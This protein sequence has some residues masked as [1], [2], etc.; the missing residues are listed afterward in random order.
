[1]IVYF[2]ATPLFRNRDGIAT[3]TIGILE[4]LL[5]RQDDN[6]YIGIAFASDKRVTGL[7]NEGDRLSFLFLPFSRR[8]YNILFKLFKLPVNV[9][10]RAKP[11]IVWYPNFVSFPYLTRVPKLVT[12]HDLTFRHNPEW[13]SKRNGRYLNRFV[14][15]SVE[16]AAA[17]ITISKSI[18]KEIQ[19]EYSP[20]KNIHVIPPSISTTGDPSG[21]EESLETF[22]L[23][24]KYLLYIGTIEPRK[25]IG[26][27]L[28]AYQLLPS[29]TK[30]AY[31]LVLVGKSGW[32]NDDLVKQIEDLK[33]QGVRWLGFTDDKD[34]L[35]ILHSAAVFILPSHYEGFGIPI[36]EAMS[37][38]VPVITSNK[39]A[40]SEIAEGYGMTIDISSPIRLANSIETLL[41]DSVLREKLVKSGRRRVNDYSWSK[42]A[43][44]LSNHFEQYGKK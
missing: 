12:V 28:D 18:R 30:A 32:K 7:L 29:K 21:F 31:D 1:M 44:M 23:N 11:D 39:G 16:K 10:L 3:Y 42:S 25:N 36:L 24:K 37:Q 27:L 33:H 4:E 2:D 5:A 8:I 38:G 15:W 14:P 13:V 9:F 17:I 43:E 35:N 41:N 40:T 26:C 20:N 6:Q 34:M 22:G 19:N